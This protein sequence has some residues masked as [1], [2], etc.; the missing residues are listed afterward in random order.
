[1]FQ[2]DWASYRRWSQE[3]QE[4]PRPGPASAHA[5]RGVMTLQWQ[6]HCVECAVP[7]CY[8]T[9]SL[10]VRRED[11]KCARLV[12]GIVRNPHFSGVLPY[13]ADL[14]FRRWGKLEARVTGRYLSVSALRLVDRADRFLT[15]CTRLGR[16]FLGHWSVWR[17][18]QGGVGWRRDRLL[19]RL[20]RQGVRFEAFAVECYSF[21]PEPY[22]LA[23]ELRKDLVTIFR[24][25]LEIRPGFN[26]DTIAIPLP[27]S[28]DNG[29]DYLL[30]VYPE[31]DVEPRLVFTMLDFVVRKGGAA[32]T[33]GRLVEPLK[34]RAVATKPAAAKPAAKVKCVAWD[35]D[36]TLWQGTLVEDG[37]DRIRLRPEAEKL[38][39]WLD[40]RGILQTVVSKNNHDAA[41]AVLQELGLEEFFL[42]PAINWGRKS[43]NLQQIADRL[44]IHI[45]TFALIDDSVFERSEVGAAL[46]M[47]RVYPETALAEL[48]RRAEFDVPVT[49]A[50]RLR[51]QSYRTEMQR[52]RAE[53]VFG[54]DHLDFLRSCDLRLRL[55]PPRSQAEIERCH[56]LVQRSNQLNLSTRRYDRKEFDALL[57]DAEMLC[58]AM[59]C[60]DRFGSYGI[61]GFA[62]VDLKGEHPTARDFVLSCRVAQ[63]HVEHAFY[64]W[65]GNCMKD[66]GA[67][68]LL[69]NL[70]KTD[71][72]SPLLRVFEEMPFTRVSSAGQEM[73][74]ALDLAGKVDLDDIVAVDDSAFHS[75]G[76]NGHHHQL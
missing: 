34:A 62:S 50:S 32:A 29:S 40:E 64:G 56:E 43:A 47:V 76:A 39:R 72:N 71:R 68:M 61:V 11:S 8:S 63:K 3:T 58:V 52:D 7:Q 38:V 5:V 14:R 22:K 15:W 53:E 42:Y 45:D 31:G 60:Q 2:F 9:C 36:N 27:A 24:A 67:R 59:E 6:E 18:I 49:E 74:L 69:L 73:L 23:L 70:I 35:L 25:G 37:K 33:E 54:A 4:S 46:P 10:Y 13:G 48:P 51:R 21:H 55:F 17:R 30:M 44:N 57:A 19:E 28:L 75:G 1:M 12:Y 66:R 20:G 65:L 41:M 16:A 26:A